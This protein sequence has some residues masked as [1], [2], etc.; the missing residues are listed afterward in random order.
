MYSNT[1]I[2]P[3]MLQGRT[4]GCSKNET[5][6]RDARSIVLTVRFILEI[7]KVF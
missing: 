3:K 1:S 4:I 5:D 6:L 7:I 2:E